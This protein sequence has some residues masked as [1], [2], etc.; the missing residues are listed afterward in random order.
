MR[1]FV[2]PEVWPRLQLT[3]PEEGEELGD[4]LQGGRR[5]RDKRK[6]DFPQSIK[7]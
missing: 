3:L 5:N 2:P 7:T 4:L 6:N 1:V